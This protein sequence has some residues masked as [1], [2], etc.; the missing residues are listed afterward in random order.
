M[1][2]D[3]PGSSR[4]VREGTNCHTPNRQLNPVAS[5]SSKI[6]EEFISG[7]AIAPDL[8]ATAVEIHSDTE[9]LPGGD[10]HYPIHSALNWRLSRFGFQARPSFAA[11][12]LLNEDGTLWQAK[13]SDP[14]WDKQKGKARK[15]ETPVGAGSKPYLPP[16]P[17]STWKTICDRHQLPY[18]A[19][20][21]QWLQKSEQLLTAQ[22]FWTWVKHNP[23]LP[24]TLT[25]GG[26]KALCLLSLGEVAIA[27]YGVHGGYRTKDSLGHSIPPQLIP[28][29]DPF[30]TQGRPVTLAFDQDAKPQTIKTVNNAQL[31]FGNLLQQA[32]AEV[33]VAT[34]NSEEGKGVDDLVVA[35]GPQAWETAYSE[36]LSLHHWQ[37]AQRLNQQLTYTA[38][39]ELNC[40]DL[41][42]IDLHQIP[43][44]GI[45]AI[46][47]PKGTGKTKLINQQITQSEKVLLASHRIALARHLGHRLNLD[48][49]G[50]LD[51]VDGQFITGSAYTLRIG[52]CVDSLLAIN[53]LHFQGCDLVIDEIVQVLRHLLTSSTCNHNGK[54]PALLARFQAILQTARRIIVA[55]ADLDDATLD[56]LLKLRDNAELFLLRNTHTLQG[57]PVQFLEAQDRTPICDRLLQDLNTLSPHQ[58]LYITTDSK[59]T[60]KT[61][62]QL[63]QTQHPDK[64]ILLI[65]SETS[66]GQD[67]REF[68]ANPDQVLQRHEYDVIICSPSVATGTSIE[69]NGIITKVYGIYMGVSATDA[70]IAQ[71][72]ARV[73]EPIPRVVWCAQRGRNFCKV[74]RSTNSLE[75]KGH[76]FERTTATTSLI[77]TSLR[78]DTIAALTNFDWTTDP[79]VHLYTKISASQNWSM[80]NLRDALRVRLIVEGHQLQIEQRD[81]NPMISEL[82]QLNGL[83]VK[84]ADAES[85]LNADTLSFTE[86]L[87]LEQKEALSPEQQRALTKFHLKDFYQLEDLTLEDILADREGRWRGELL[88]LEAQLYPNV[89]LDRTVKALEKQRSWRQFLCPWDIPGTAIR[90]EIRDK[91]GLTEF[92]RTAATGW[93]WT[94]R[95]LAPIAEMARQYAPTIKA[96]LNFTISARV[97]D[98]QIVHQLL[99]QLG[100]KTKFRWSSNHPS[101]PGKKI[102]VY[103]LKLDHWE[104]CMA[105]LD[106]RALNRQQK[107]EQAE[108]VPVER[109]PL[110]LDLITLKGDL[111]ANPTLSPPF[112]HPAADEAHFSQLQLPTEILIRDQEEQ[113]PSAGP[114]DQALSA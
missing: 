99:S 81:V 111:P 11:A 27:L 28:E 30:I 16:I 97:S 42:E 60:S 110:T 39:L 69:V 5:F 68:I 82:L 73:R 64:R 61:L 24:L 88:N 58:V 22:G 4:P 17:Y 41:S 114:P 25:E 49:R 9:Q 62:F 104:Q 79:H 103:G 55:D 31:K 32:G 71:A 15:Y 66:G 75:L 74:S 12:F 53:P 38:N 91:L 33:S 51:R 1:I 56:Y 7:S 70:D 44:E 36:A 98:T 95:D 80:Y 57:Y 86:V 109:S 35:K 14:I 90:R 21:Q 48:Y 23:T 83:A 2:Q 84:Q 59:G 67:E 46:A 89:A 50:D 112:T 77:R 102:R 94:G 40:P 92:I 18:P 47:S 96:H 8:F 78:P 29:L 26:K 85:I 10:V 34:W 3:R 6:K 93:E 76:L 100:I 106:R 101:Y 72:L 63:L 108:L 52:F 20:L 13:L 87:A 43:T 54:R 105:I 37:I 45:I 113:D 19:E 65:N 107:L